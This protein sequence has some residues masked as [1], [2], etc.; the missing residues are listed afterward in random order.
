MLRI[1]IPSR[2]VSDVIQLS[3]VPKG[4]E[5]IFLAEKGTHQDIL[6]FQDGF[7]HWVDFYC[8]EI[9]TARTKYF[10]IHD[11]IESRM[12]KNMTVYMLRNKTELKDMIKHNK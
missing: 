11:A 6:T 9:Y 3:D 1:S 5:N 7:Y 12:N 2:E 4:S 8:R 10:T